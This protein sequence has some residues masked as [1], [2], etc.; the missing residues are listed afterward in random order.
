MAGNWDIRRYGSI[1]STNDEAR[2]LALAGAADGTVVVAEG[3]TAGRGRAGRNW[4]S[5]E[6]KGLYCSLVARPGRA[7]EECPSLALVAGLAVCD[8]CETFVEIPAQ[9]KWP[10][11]V[12]LAGKKVC[13]I[14]TELVARPNRPIVVIV[15][16]GIN[17]NLRADDLPAELH[18]TAT[19]LAIARGQPLDR[20]LVLQAVLRTWALRYGKWRAGGFAALRA[21]YYARAAIEGHRVAVS[22]GT[23]RCEGIVRGVDERGALLLER[24]PGVVEAIIAGDVEAL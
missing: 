19:S 8:A 5:P 10:N 20:E 24:A 18:P 13:G 16:I 17:V 6:G 23:E 4:F 2:A 14:L 15:G 1:G 21:D 11:D 7:K 3:Q 12:W 22:F 9:V